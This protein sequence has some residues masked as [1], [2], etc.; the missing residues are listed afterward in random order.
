M[1]MVPEIPCY[2]CQHF[3]C[4]T[5]LGRTF[6]GCANKQIGLREYLSLSTKGGEC[7]SREVV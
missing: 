1:I 2:T 5:M 3:K 7:P 6:Y 4:R